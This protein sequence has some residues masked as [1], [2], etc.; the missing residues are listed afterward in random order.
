[1]RDSLWGG[2]SQWRTNK[3][4]SL[5]YIHFMYQILARTEK[6]NSIKFWYDL[7]NF[8]NVKNM[9]YTLIHLVICHISLLYS[10]LFFFYNPRLFTNKK[11]G[12]WVI[13]GLILIADIYKTWYEICLDVKI[14][15]GDTYF[16]NTIIITGYQERCSVWE[17]KV[18]I[19]VRDQIFLNERQIHDTLL[20]SR[21]LRSRVEG[22]GGRGGEERYDISLA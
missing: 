21:T 9:A 4:A 2:S 15:E 1:M 18:R 3:N 11:G 16:Q 10:S 22:V 12:W 19:S 17:I 6:E 20:N 14:C 5:F 8:S 13:S 7:D